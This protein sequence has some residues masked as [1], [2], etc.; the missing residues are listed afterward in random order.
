MRSASEF[1]LQSSWRFIYQ[2]GCPRCGFE[3]PEAKHSF[4]DGPALCESCAA[5]VAPTIG[6]PCDRC[7]APVGPYVDSSNGC[8]YCRGERF[9]FEKVIRLGV[10][11][12]G[13]REVCLQGKT[14]SGQAIVSAATMLLWSRELSAFS[15]LKADV[16]L[17]VP[18]HWTDRFARSSH[19]TGTI[20]RLISRRLQLGEPAPILKKIRRTLVQS[21]LPAGRRRTNVKGAFR[22]P[23]GIEL[24]GAHVLLVDDVLTTGATAD[25]ASKILKQAGAT[26]VTVAVLARGLGR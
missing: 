2:D 6:P 5:E 3:H 17:P 13:L 9:H 11:D 4:V 25:E 10:Y 12:G 14:A 1:L 7:G 16:V 19:S 23:R 15:N 18:R 22:V 24:A 21:S 26:R 8:T 20:A